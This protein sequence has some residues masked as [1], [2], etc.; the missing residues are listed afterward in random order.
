[1]PKAAKKT[2][3]MRASRHPPA[4]KEK[5]IALRARGLSI[6][7]IAKELRIGKTTLVSWNR[8]LKEEVAAMRAVELEALREKYFLATER[9][10]AL[11]G[12]EVER[13]QAELSKRDYSDI[14]TDKLA[15]TLLKVYRALEAEDVEPVFKTE[16]EVKRARSTW[17][18]LLK[19]AQP[20]KGCSVQKVLSLFVI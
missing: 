20:E 2:P 15:D 13:I 3:A 12:A 4:K 6:E 5:F 19:L 17:H 9:R 7:K 10:I 11:F 8:E 1:M 14:P 18:T 16:E